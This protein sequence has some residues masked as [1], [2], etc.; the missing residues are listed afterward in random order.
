MR[1]ETNPFGTALHEPSGK[2]YSNAHRVFCLTPSQQFDCNMLKDLGHSPRRL[3]HQQCGGC[4][5]GI[6]DRYTHILL[7]IDKQTKIG[8]FVRP[9]RTKH[10]THEVHT[11][12]T[13]SIWWPPIGRGMARVCAAASVHSS[14]TPSSVAFVATAIFIAKKTTSGM[15]LSAFFVF[16]STRR[17]NQTDNVLKKSRRSPAANHENT[18]ILAFVSL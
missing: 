9:A 6:R 12:F 16:P 8:S 15:C 17:P 11:I 10:L 14:W 5:C 2:Y 3:E 1:L 4:G 7:A 18:I 13:D